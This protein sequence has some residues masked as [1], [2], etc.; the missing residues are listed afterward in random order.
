MVD[1]CAVAPRLCMSPCCAAQ[2]T[3]YSQTLSSRLTLKLYFMIDSCEY[4]RLV[5]LVGRAYA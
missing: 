3:D 1:N 5:S 2:M 4:P